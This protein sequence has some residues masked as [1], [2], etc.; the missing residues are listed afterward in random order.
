MALMPFLSKPSDRAR[1]RRGVTQ[2]HIASCQGDWPPPQRLLILNLR[3]H[4]PFSVTLVSR[5]LAFR[6][7]FAIG[8]VML[9]SQGYIKWGRIGV[10][11][12]KKPTKKTIGQT[13]EALRVAKGWE[14]SRLAKACRVSRPAIYRWEKA[15]Y[16][17]EK[18]LN[19]LA[20]VLGI[21]VDELRRL[22]NQGDD[23]E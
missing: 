22:N 19:A 13:I 11:S 16:I 1:S 18:N 2:A 3:I 4:F 23:T 15:T 10:P 8:I 6:A 14:R 9:V 12:K 21:P 17:Q 7:V 20:R 5:R